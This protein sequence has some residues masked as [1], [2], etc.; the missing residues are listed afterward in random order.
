MTKPNGRDQIL[1]AAL[2][3]FAHNGFDGA[4]IRDIAQRADL[5]LSALYYYFSSKK[6]ALFALVEKAYS[7]YNARTAEILTH[8]PDDV[9]AQ[10][11]YGV[12]HLVSYRCINVMYSRVILLETGRL[13]GPR[14][15][16]AH[17]MQRES[18]SVF[19]KIIARGRSQG[20]FHVDDPALMTRSVNA[21][22]NAIPQWFIPGGA[23]TPES[24][25]YQY[26]LTTLRMLGSEQAN[27]IEPFFDGSVD[28]SANHIDPVADAQ[29]G[30]E[31]EAVNGVR[32]P[33]L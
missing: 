3:T 4:S 15:A 22:C 7:T 17:E 1:Q 21:M 31:G 32:L 30:A 5:S 27:N 29:N 14:Y 25:A 33:P 13:A 19:E 28:V 26:V 11:A 2:V 8:A 16:Q 24:L 18:S 6:E 10:V 9:N 20:I 12:Q 23:Y